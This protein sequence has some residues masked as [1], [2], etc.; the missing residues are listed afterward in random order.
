MLIGYVN[1]GLNLLCKPFG[2]LDENRTARVLLV[3]IKAF[4]A[5]GHRTIYYG[6]KY[7]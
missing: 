5:P 2:K 1:T 3:V 7:L 6:K 4:N